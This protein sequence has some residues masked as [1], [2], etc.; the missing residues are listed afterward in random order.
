[1]SEE[2][3]GAGRTKCIVKGCINHTD[4]GG[5]IGVLCG[6]CYQMITTGEVKWGETFV[7]DLLFKNK[8][9]VELLEA[10]KVL[11]KFLK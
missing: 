8:R 5:F 9:A 11:R 3:L 4:E 7:H 10:V 6:P 1:M 2:T